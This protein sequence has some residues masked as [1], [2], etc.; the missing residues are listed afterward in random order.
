[1]HTLK[2][3]IYYNDAEIAAQKAAMFNGMMVNGK[4]LI[5]KK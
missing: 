4:P 5:I 3:I 1:M 2:G